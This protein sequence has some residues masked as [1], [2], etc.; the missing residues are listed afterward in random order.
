MQST[1]NDRNGDRGRP[2]QVIVRTTWI[3]RG[4]GRVTIRPHSSEDSHVLDQI[5]KKLILV[6]KLYSALLPY[7]VY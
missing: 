3:T 7:H 6:G 1:D 4:P 2:A 5:D